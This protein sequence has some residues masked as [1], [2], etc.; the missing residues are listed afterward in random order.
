MEAVLLSI[1]V[2]ETTV[3]ISDYKCRYKA[4]YTSLKYINAFYCR[5]DL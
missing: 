3:L 5:E 1:D 4:L 2:Y